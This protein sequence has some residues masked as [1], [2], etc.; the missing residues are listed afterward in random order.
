[1]PGKIALTFDDGPYIY[2]SSL[3]DLLSKQGIKATFFVT[4]VN[5]GKGDISE[6]S[7]GY[8]GIIQRMIK[9]GH[10][11]ASHTWSHADLTLLNHQQ[12]VDQLVKNEIALTKI[13]GFFPTYMRPPYSFV[14]ADV[15]A[16]MKTLGY[17]VVSHP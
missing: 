10:Q 13:L 8:P 5:G 2:T 7:T 17:H 6:P 16:D 12:R 1:V 14:N 11:V 3:L 9:D 4:G 15:L